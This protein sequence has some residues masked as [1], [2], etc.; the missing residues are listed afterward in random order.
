MQNTLLSRPSKPRLN[1]FRSSHRSA[2]TPLM[3]QIAVFDGTTAPTQK[4]YKEGYKEREKRP[5]DIGKPQQGVVRA[6]ERGL[7]RGEART[8]PSG[9]FCPNNHY[10]FRNL[11]PKVYKL[12]DSVAWI[13]YQQVLDIGSGL[14][15]NAIYLAKKGLSVTGV[16]FSPEALEEARKRLSEASSPATDKLTFLEGDAFSLDTILGDK[17]FDTALDCSLMHCFSPGDQ[18]RYIS[19]LSPHVRLSK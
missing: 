8:R 9:L 16:D 6:F 10:T 5:W 12:S 17:A 1:I 19:S 11:E 7:F 18:K 3:S 13:A 14:G 4:H 2:N 15:D